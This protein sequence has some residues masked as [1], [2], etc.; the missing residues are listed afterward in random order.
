MLD[1]ETHWDSQT[2]SFRCCQYLLNSGFVKH[3][4]G[5]LQPDDS[6]GTADSVLAMG[7]DSADLTRPFQPHEFTSKVE[8]AHF[9]TAQLVHLLAKNVCLCHE[10]FGFSEEF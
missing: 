6:T 4:V 8:R 9:Y 3:L 10:R 7:R 5:L 1:R 2:V